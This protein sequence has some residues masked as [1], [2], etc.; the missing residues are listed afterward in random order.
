MSTPPREVLIALAMNA[1]AQRLLIDELK[2]ARPPV[3]IYDSS[4]I[5]VPAWGEV[6]A[7]TNNVRHYEVSEYVLRGWTPVLRTH[8][9]LVMARNDLVASRP[10]PALSTSSAVGRR[11]RVIDQLPYGPT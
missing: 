1:H 4:S 3:V 6:R 9:V 8:G 5:G 11:R 7:I 10:M 2:A